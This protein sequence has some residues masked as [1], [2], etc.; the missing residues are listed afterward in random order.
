LK[1]IVTTQS[2]CFNPRT[3]VGCDGASVFPPWRVQGFNPRTHV[4]C[5]TEGLVVTASDME[6]QSTH[7]RGVRRCQR[8]GFPI[9][10]PF[11]STHPRGVRHSGVS[12]VAILTCFNP[13]TH[14]GCDAVSV[15]DSRFSIR[16]NPRTHV[17]CDGD[18]AWYYRWGIVSIHA[19][20]WGAT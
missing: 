6:F 11:Q 9:L 8:C 3:H 13:R 2:E 14:V 12:Q 7:P 17:G 10:N 16:F 4:G 15:V 5:D 20:T 1:E 19:P 18:G